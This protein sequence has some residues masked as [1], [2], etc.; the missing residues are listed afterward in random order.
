MS[1]AA[2]QR[3][4]I[5]VLNRIFKPTAG[6]AERYSIALVEQLAQRHEIHVFA[7][8]I[9][10]QWPGVHYH[11]IP[12][13][14]ARPRWLNQ[15]WFALATWWQTRRGFDVVHSHENTWHGRVQTVHVVPVTYSLLHGLSGTRLALRWLKIATSPRLMAYLALEHAR[16]NLSDGRCIV[17]ASSTQESVMAASFPE[18]VSACEVVTP[19][20]GAVPGRS[21]LDKRVAA[22][23][24]LGLPQLGRCVLFVG[25]DFRKKGLPTLIAALVHLPDD[26]FV[27]VVGNAA[28]KALIQQELDASG[29]SARIFFLGAL[30]AVD[31]AYQAA[32]CLAHPTLED[33]FAMVVLEAMAHGLPVVVSNASFCGISALLTADVD[34][35]LLTDPRDVTS[36]HTAL[37]RVLEEGTLTECLRMQGLRFAR[38]HVWSEI[39]LHQEVIYHAVAAKT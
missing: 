24:Q 4:R 16:Y 31:V 23:T 15:L 22:R 11:R 33:T 35:L 28:Q 17:L 6:G 32:D 21:T 19:G 1:T 8:Q 36:L 18:C 2:P 12:L 3:L 25:N 27:A 26:V 20:V 30:P 7:Q 9:D 10:H 13:P 29:Q 14:F 39:A 34:A 38:Q 5:A 37:E